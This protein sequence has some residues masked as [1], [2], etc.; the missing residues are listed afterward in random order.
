MYQNEL[1]SSGVASRTLVEVGL[2]KNEE[3]ACKSGSLQL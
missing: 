2:G 3:M 1:K